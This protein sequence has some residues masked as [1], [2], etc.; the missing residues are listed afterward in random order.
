MLQRTPQNLIINNKC[1][2]VCVYKYTVYR[3]L[4]I[5][6]V[7]EATQRLSVEAGIPPNYLP[8]N[9]LENSDD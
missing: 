9:L 5:P 6:T 2:A 8:V 7:Q 4:K 3:D 1:A